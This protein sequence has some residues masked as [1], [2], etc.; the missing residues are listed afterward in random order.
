MLMSLGTIFTVSD[1][2]FAIFCKTE[3]PDFSNNLA[4]DSC[5]LDCSLCLQICVPYDDLQKNCP[6]CAIFNNSRSTDSLIPSLT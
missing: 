3:E 1:F 5:W 6:R 4:Q 2:K